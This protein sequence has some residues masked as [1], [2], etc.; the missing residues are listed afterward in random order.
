[1]EEARVPTTRI[2]LADRIV[3]LWS[4]RTTASDDIVEQCRRILAPGEREQAARFRSDHLRHS[5]I[6]TRGALRVLLGRYLDADPA[7]LQF[8]YGAKGKP[9]LGANSCIKFNSSHSGELAVFAFTLDCEIGIDIEQIYPLPRIKDIA[10]RFFCEEE[11]GELLSLPVDQRERAFFLCWTRKE[12]CIKSTGD[13][14]SRSLDSFQ[15]TLRPG[16]KARF[17]HFDHDAR[18]ATAWALHDLEL[19]PGYAAA[20]AYRDERRPIHVLLPIEPAQL[21]HIE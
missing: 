3:Q 7:R 11:S 6:L 1:M 12:A 5:F 13:G 19:A 2:E 8:T 15:V 20:L 10:G 21:F 16:E 17:V 4:V 9:S 18:A 14:L